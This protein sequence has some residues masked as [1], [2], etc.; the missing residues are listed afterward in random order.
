MHK[1]HRRLAGLVMAA[2]LA[3]S[4]LAVGGAQAAPVQALP[5]GTTQAVGDHLIQPRAEIC[6]NY[7][8][9]S[10]NG[11]A[12]LRMQEDGNF[13]LYKDGRAVWQAPGAWGQGDC[14]AFQEDGNL[15]VYD[16]GGNPLWASDTWGTGAYLAIQD[17]GNTV[18]YDSSG[19]PVWATDT[20]D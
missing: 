6:R 4:G 18:I 7:A 19:T 9:T 12:I 17:D 2:S 11:R 3:V 10:G 5:Q 8:W 13:V 14:A 20:G 1:S 15:V 16:N